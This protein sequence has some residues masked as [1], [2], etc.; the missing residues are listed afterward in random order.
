MPTAI[1]PKIFARLL[2]M[3]MKAAT[4]RGFVN[5]P[6]PNLTHAKQT[7]AVTSLP[8]MSAGL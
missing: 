8:S 1:A 5:G 3:A 2:R 4:C 6:L 7:A